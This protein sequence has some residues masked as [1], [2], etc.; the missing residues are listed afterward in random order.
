MKRKRR[1]KKRNV[2]RKKKKRKKR[3]RTRK[4]RKMTRMKKEEVQQEVLEEEKEEE[5]R[6]RMI[7]RMIT[8]KRRMR[9][10]T[11]TLL[12]RRMTINQPQLSLWNQ[13]L[14]LR[15]WLHSVMMKHR[16]ILLVESGEHLHLIQKRIQIVQRFVS[17]RLKTTIT[18][19]KPLLSS[20]PIVRMF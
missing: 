4:E 10:L 18:R 9:V 17:E 20:Q 16:W 15:V 12:L 5:H 3:I 6:I 19:S 11:M 14:I 13:E 7:R 2:R 1:K 8:Q